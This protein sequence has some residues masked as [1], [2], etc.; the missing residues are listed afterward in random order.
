MLF[1]IFTPASLGFTPR[2]RSS[3]CSIPCASTLPIGLSTH[4]ALISSL[5]VAVL[6]PLSWPFPPLGPQSIRNVQIEH[7]D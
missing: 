5:V 1:R 6:A 2:S 7:F 4:A 3:T